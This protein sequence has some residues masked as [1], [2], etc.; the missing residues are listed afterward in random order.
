[1]AYAAVLFDLFDTLVRF[2][3]QRMPEI[4]IDGKAVPSS[5]GLLHGLLCVHAP[6]IGLVQCYEALSDS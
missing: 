5:A 2:D 6:H 1:M 3:R 4:Q